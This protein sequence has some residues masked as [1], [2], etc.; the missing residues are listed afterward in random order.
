[1]LRDCCSW[2]VDVLGEHMRQLQEGAHLLGNVLHGFGVQLCAVE[3]RRDLQNLVPCPPKKSQNHNVHKKS[4]LQSRSLSL[5][6]ICRAVLFCSSCLSRFNSTSL[7][8][9]S[10]SPSHPFAHLV[11]PCAPQDLTPP[12]MPRD[13]PRSPP[14][15]RRSGHRTEQLHGAARMFRARMGWRHGGGCRI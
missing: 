5:I 14:S 8:Q 2:A 11:T 9:Q 1:M 15:H 6:H 4:R 10:C 12:P 13:A 3:G 7:C